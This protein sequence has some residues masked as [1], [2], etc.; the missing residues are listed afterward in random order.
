MREM[1]HTAAGPVK[2]A[3]SRGFRPL[4]EQT[5]TLIQLAVIAVTFCRL[6]TL[7]RFTGGVNASAKNS[8]STGGRHRKAGGAALLSHQ[9]TI[10]CVGNARQSVRGPDGGEYMY[11]L[12][13]LFP[14]GTSSAEDAKQLSWKQASEVHAWRSE[15]C[16]RMRRVGQFPYQ[17][18][19]WFG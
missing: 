15:S 1:N 10:S 8:S 12:P 6:D 19:N 7:P 4:F 9:G 5:R 3:A 17:P 13:P 11:T 2:D 18:D 14:S 16:F